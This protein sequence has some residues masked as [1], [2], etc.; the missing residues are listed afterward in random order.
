M[1]PTQARSDRLPRSLHQSFIMSEK[2][3]LMLPVLATLI[4]SVMAF[5][6]LIVAL[7]TEFTLG[8]VIVALLFGGGAVYTGLIAFR[9]FRHQQ[10]NAILTGVGQEQSRILKLAAR[11]DG[12]LTPEETAME[13]SLSVQQAETL[14]DDLVNQG[15][16]ETW[17]TDE[18]SMVYVFRNLTDGNKD[19]AEDPMKMLES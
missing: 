6:L 8:A 5:S 9:N 17:V 14:L 7:F 18:G 1:L 16:A 11:E 4:C 13:C 19:S 10:D 12:R 3:R 2:L 15:R